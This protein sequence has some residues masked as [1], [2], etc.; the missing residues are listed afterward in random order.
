MAGGRRRPSRASGRRGGAGPEQLTRSAV[1][2]RL[3][4]DLRKALHLSLP[5]AAARARTRVDVVD[6]LERGDVR[7]L[8]PWPETE[9]VVVAYTALAGIDAGPVL[10]VIRRELEDE[11]HTLDLVPNPD[12][13]AHESGGYLYSLRQQLR[14]LFKQAFVHMHPD[15]ADFDEEG[16]VHRARRWVLSGLRFATQ[17][18]RRAL[19]LALIVSLALAVLIGDRGVLRSA[20]AHLPAPLASAARSVD[21]TLLRIG[22]GVHEGLIWIDVDDARSRKGDKL[23][24]GRR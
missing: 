24:T 10:N 8:P 19:G 6:A 17:S 13:S 14:S 2:G 7:I 18:R 4:L 3:F 20:A 1:V 9:R 22:A 15:S 23:Q 11:A 5:E 12:P 21:D 16:V